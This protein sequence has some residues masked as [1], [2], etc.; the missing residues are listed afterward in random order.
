MSDYKNIIDKAT[1]DMIAYAKKLVTLEENFRTY[2]F[3]KGLD[4]ENYKLASKEYSEEI[5]LMK[6]KIKEIEDK[7]I[8][9]NE[10]TE[11]VSGDVLK[12]LNIELGIIWRII[13]A[14]QVFTNSAITKIEEKGGK[15]EV[16]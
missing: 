1:N 12:E 2:I 5:K 8:E 16:I 10:E 13:T 15:V 7:I 9:I 4:E 11:Y 6:P 14:N 3:E